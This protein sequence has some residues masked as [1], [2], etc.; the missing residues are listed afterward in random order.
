MRFLLLVLLLLAAPLTVALT[1]G[2]GHDPAA[3]AAQ[4]PWIH[5]SG[6]FAGAAECRSCH[7]DHYASWRRTFHASMTQAP[8][9]GRAHV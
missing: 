4:A 8:K 6:G 3:A 7:P 9:I 1:L 5:R 2:F